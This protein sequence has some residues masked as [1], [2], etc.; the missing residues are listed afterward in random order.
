MNALPKYRYERKFAISGLQ[1]SQVLN[2]IKI[3]PA[4]FRSSFPD[5][6]VNN[7]YLDDHSYRTFKDN[8]SG[9]AKRKKIRL[10]WYGD[11]FDNQAKMSLE[12]KFRNNF[13]GSKE[14]YPVAGFPIKHG[15]NYLLL[16]QHLMDAN[17]PQIIQGEVSLLQPTLLNSYRRKYFESID[18]RFRLT[19]DDQN[20]YTKITTRDCNFKH[21][22]MDHHRIIVE[23]KY[24]YILE[25]EARSIINA[26]PFRMTKNSKYVN[27]LLALNNY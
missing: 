14:S 26:F 25:N 1:Y 7:I 18:R 24:D 3:N 13:V 11:T 16:Q 9:I 10:R 19:L 15:F 20:C 4:A 12:Y 23:L 21:Q 8:I 22:L 2:Y 5:R 6:Q 27:G 17:L